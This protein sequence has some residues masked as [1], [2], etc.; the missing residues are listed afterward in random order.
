MNSDA[1]IGSSRPLK[2]RAEDVLRRLQKS[3]AIPGGHDIASLIHELSVHQIELEMQGEELRRSAE[4][5][6]R[7]R[8]LYFQHFES[9]PIPIFRF[10][11]DG[12]VLETNL[13]GAEMV[14][15]RR[16]QASSPPRL[17]FEHHLAD[18][19]PREFRNLIARAASGSGPVST[20]L[21]IRQ[22]HGSL[23][24]FLVTALAV[25]ESSEP[26]VLA[27][28]HD[29]TARRE[30]SEE[31]E[32]LSL[33]AKHTADAVVFTDA[34]A[35][36]VW[37][38]EAFPLLTGYSA[39]EVIGMKPSMM[40]GPGTDPATVG[41]L[42]EA[43]AHGR[44]IR[45]DVLNY[46]K[47]GRPYWVALEIIPIHDARGRLSGFMSMD[48][49]ITERVKRER[50]LLSLRT[51]VDQSDNSILIT[52]T[53]GRIEFVNPAFTR[54]TGYQPAEVLGR[55]PNILKSGIQPDPHYRE[56]WA[57]ITSG[58]I[59]RGNFC[60]KR[61]DGSL[62]WES[63]TISPVLDANGRIA[64]FIAITENIDEKIRMMHALQSSTKL[65]DETGQ[66]AGI[67][68]W[69]LDLE[70]RI[71]RW[72]SQTRRLHEV[73]DDYQP[74]LNTALDF[75]PPEARDKVKKSIDD[76]IREGKPW[77]F[78]V[79]FTTGR[80][81]PI[82]VRV[83]GS[84]EL[85]NGKVTRLIGAF[86]DVTARREAEEEIRETHRKLVI[87]SERAE[88]ASRAKSDFLAN[89]SH[90][91]R[92]PLNAV[93]GMSELLEEDL[94]GPHAMEYL[95]TI[96]TS[97]AAL[98]AI[99][100]DILD[101][102]KIE[103]GAM[104]LENHPF[105]L[106]DCVRHSMKTVSA[107]AAA[108][109][110]GF[111][112]ALAEDLPKE[113]VGDPLRLRQVLVNLLSNAVKFTDTGEVRLEIRRQA[114]QL[115]ISVS[116]TGIGIPQERMGRLFQSFSQVDSSTSRRYGGTGL[117]LA[118]SQRIVH[119]MGG[120]IEVESIPGSGTRFYFSLPIREPSSLHDQAPSPQTLPSVEANAGLEESTSGPTRQ[121]RILVA[122]DNPVSQRL[123]EMMLK[124]LGYPCRLVSNGKE[125]LAALEKE[126][127]DL[128]FMDL[129]MPVMD[130]YEAV[131]Q[132]GQLHSKSSRPWIV[133]LTANVL[134]RDRDAC[135]AAGMD[136]F[137]AKPISRAELASVLREYQTIIDSRRRETSRITYAGPL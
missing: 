4:A 43:V 110:I 80:G 35:H 123:M 36:I 31:Y 3:S 107:Q 73:P 47:D 135:H 13:A 132:I 103:A 104:E 11:P 85:E 40:Q 25:A 115:A 71:P 121:L 8:K 78:E 15:L 19:Q 136:L 117:G 68:G 28:F 114:S 79:P 6:E 7:A 58:N 93:L 1:D 95:E 112:C 53:K 21:S 109:G 76:A 59:W 45:E 119:M 91:I 105:A 99:V 87:E 14:G 131:E 100:N 55:N 102:S 67:G 134:E 5:M 56:L 26:S 30:I 51:A 57:T 41:R 34:N 2:E 96:R 83:M 127:F 65:L 64:R 52:D 101:F 18:G 94:N 60:N 27:Y 38:N 33:L 122:E 81:R 77:D 111:I 82:L 23:R 20:S 69:E 97:G 88:A 125:A 116:D 16:G 108:K 133:A 90:E 17:C 63:A 84:P 70:T 50:E 118:I 46:T 106:R 92:T 113:I 66:V 74:D 61:K 9:A 24:H 89:M 98:L 120:H 37:V 130:G 10:A 44:H 49:D 22:N 62:Y 29:E 126:S 124:V 42:H 128:I 86:Q 137:M 54:N 32:R 129:Q 72:T 75:Y 39:E 48:R 12:G